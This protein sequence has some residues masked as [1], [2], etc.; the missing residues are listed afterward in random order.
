MNPFDFADYRSYFQ[1]LT[2]KKGAARGMKAALA[3]A[4]KCQASYFSQVLKGRAHFTEDQIFSLSK[5]LRL[6]SDESDYLLLLLRIEKAGSPELKEFLQK[7]LEHQQTKRKKLENRVGSAKVIQESEALGIYFSSWIPS[8][9]HLLTSSPKFRKAEAIASRLH[10]PLG[11]VKET[12][13]FLESYGFVQRRSG[14]WVY[15]KGSIHLSKDSPHQSAM[16]NSRRELAARSIALNPE[17]TIHYSSLFTIDARELEKVKAILTAAI[18]Q[19]Q[20]AVHAS[21]TDHLA[22]VCIDAF[23]VV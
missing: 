17:D 1:E 3:R 2:A 11:K 10:L 12:L 21:G 5:H 6:S 16:Q 15:L 22:C 23:E 9:I 13:L 19:S 20:K 4:A 8:A 18:E 7:S 14:D